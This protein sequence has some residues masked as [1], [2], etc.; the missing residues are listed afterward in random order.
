MHAEQVQKL[1]LCEQCFFR[2]ESK[3]ILGH[4]SK[5]WI[6]SNTKQKDIHT[7]PKLLFNPSIFHAHFTLHWV[8][9]YSMTYDVK[10]QAVLK[11]HH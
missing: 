8:S 11:I 9:K 10:I 1:V 6:K 4:Y 3:Q 7:L 2:F 5:F